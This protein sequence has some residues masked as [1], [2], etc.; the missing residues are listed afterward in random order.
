[1]YLLPFTITGD[2]GLKHLQRV[3]DSHDF[4]A[5]KSLVFLFAEENK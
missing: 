3:E 2:R 5:N 1:M 4:S